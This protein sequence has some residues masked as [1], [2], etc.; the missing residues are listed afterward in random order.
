HLNG[1]SMDYFK[2]SL[3][4]AQVRAGRDQEVLDAIPKSR[5]DPKVL[6]EAFKALIERGQFETAEA[7]LNK[8]PRSERDGSPSQL[9]AACANSLAVALA[10]ADRIADAERVLASAPARPAEEAHADP[11]R[12]AAEW[13]IAGA[14]RRKGDA[15]GYEAIRK[16]LLDAVKAASGAP[17]L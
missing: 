10:D 5:F 1:Q 4:V 16:P 9:R 11:E 14:K 13:A 17:S 12:R 3:L 8:F 6:T 2:G 7:M 15:A